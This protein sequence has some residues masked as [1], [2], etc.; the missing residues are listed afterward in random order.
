VS[1]VGASEERCRV[2]ILL[3]VGA[4]HQRLLDEGLR[5][6]TSLVAETDEAR[7]THDAATLLGY[8]ADAIV[9]RL[10]LQTIT[11]L[12]DEGRIGGDGPA[13]SIAQERYRNAI[14]DGVL[15][16]MSKMGISVLDSYRGRRSSRRSGSGP[17]SSTPASRGPCRSSAA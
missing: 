10:V 1:D 17:T 3:A 6:R 11:D 9:P 7:E 13:A 15:K 2:P 12:A 16:I 5:T 4:V 8:G 14:E